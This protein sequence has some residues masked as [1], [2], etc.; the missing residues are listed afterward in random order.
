MH[1]FIVHFVLFVKHFF[2]YRLMLCFRLQTQIVIIF[3]C[4]T[5]KHSD[6]TKKGE[7]KEKKKGIQNTS[8]LMIHNNILCV[9]LCFFLVFKNFLTFL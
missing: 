1:H 9:L 5:F 6:E 2:V 7:E 3:N 4:W 8:I